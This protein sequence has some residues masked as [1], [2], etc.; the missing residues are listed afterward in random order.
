MII[1]YIFDD[2][3][4]M[5]AIEQMT[6]INDYA[7]EHL[8][9]PVDYFA[10]G[11]SFKVFDLLEPLDTVIVKS[12]EPWGEAGEVTAIV[13][14]LI[15]NLVQVINLSSPD[16]CHALAGRDT[17]MLRRPTAATDRSLRHGRI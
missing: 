15:L 14:G 17:T 1:G 5:D 11:D 2:N 13:S 8:T 7:A 3:D 9:R 12:L 16:T 6:E 4:Q 10:L